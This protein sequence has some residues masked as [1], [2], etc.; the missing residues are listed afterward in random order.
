MDPT[1]F[2]ETDRADFQGRDVVGG[3]PQ[4]D[5]LQHTET[6]TD[7]KDPRPR[8][9]GPRPFL[10]ALRIPGRRQEPPRPSLTASTEVQRGNQRRRELRMASPAQS[11]HIYLVTVLWRPEPA[12]TSETATAQSCAP[13][14]ITFL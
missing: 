6:S 13:H 5:T 3:H 4:G 8:G 10:R 9:A 11:E 1:Y 7:P 14:T 2:R 12:C